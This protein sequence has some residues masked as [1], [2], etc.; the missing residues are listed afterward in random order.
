MEVD[1]KIK[2][3]CFKYEAKAGPTGQVWRRVKRVPFNEYMADPRVF[4]TYIHYHE[5]QTIRIEMPE[6]RFR[7]L[8]E[9][10]QWVASA[11]LHENKHFSNN[12]MRVSELIVEHETECKIRNENPAV[13]AAYEKYLMLLELAR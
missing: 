1:K 2:E 8:L 12:V 11:G 4:E 7:A 10:E 13:K 3:F 9:H 6:D 5:I